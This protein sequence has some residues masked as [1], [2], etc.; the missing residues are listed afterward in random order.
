MPVS[1]YAPSSSSSASQPPASSTLHSAS[2]L[3]SSSSAATTT[4][5]VLPF[6]TEEID[7]DDGVKISCTTKELLR[8]IHAY[9]KPNIDPMNFR[10]SD[11]LNPEDDCFYITIKYKSEG[12]KSIKDIMEVL[13]YWFIELKPPTFKSAELPSS[14]LT[15]SSAAVSTS[16]TSS[17]SIA[18]SSSASGTK[19]TLASLITSFEK[20]ETVQINTAL[21]AASSSA[22]KP[23]AVSKPSETPTYEIIDNTTVK[24]QCSIGSKIRLLSEALENQFVS[25]TVELADSKKDDWTTVSGNK[26]T[27]LIIKA[28]NGKTAKD[29]ARYVDVLGFKAV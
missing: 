7:D 18:S 27:S 26:A 23:K 3:L 19:S 6:T 21:N 13:N 14:T 11:T 22:S 24:V 8:E 4:K 12:I 17:A 10:I 1:L 5:R 16:S 25:Y 28:I 20:P 29:I 9:I 15:S 2:A